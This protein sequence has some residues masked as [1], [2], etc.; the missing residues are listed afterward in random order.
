M[1]VKTYRIGEAAELLNLKSYVLRFW[2]TEFNQLE[3]LRTNK[4]QR[5]YTEEHV[6]ILMR[7]KYLLHERGL[8]IEGAKRMLAEQKA[9]LNSVD[10]LAESKAVADAMPGLPPNTQGP[11]SSAR[12]TGQ[13]DPMGPTNDTGGPGNGK[14]PKGLNLA[15]LRLKAHT[16]RTLSFLDS[17]RADFGT[18]RASPQKNPVPP[19]GANPLQPGNPPPQSGKA[20]LTAAAPTFAATDT[21]DTVAGSAPSGKHPG[22]NLDLTLDRPLNSNSTLDSTLHSNGRAKS[23]LT[24]EQSATQKAGAGFIQE[25]LEEL[26]EL[27]RMLRV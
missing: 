10:V 27:R 18:S 17:L 6:R 22:S 15:H 13:A 20:A 14:R 5:L 19:D 8:T 4:G 9:G 24:S 23:A 26:E 21:A 16:D 12:V 3:P 7:I 25:L 11:G 1:S 2:E